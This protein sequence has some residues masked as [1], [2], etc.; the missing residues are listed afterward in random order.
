MQHTGD[1]LLGG[2]PFVSRT[3][4]GTFKDT[5]F[6]LDMDANLYIGPA[7]ALSRDEHSAI[8]VVFQF[9]R[10]T[11]KLECS[12]REALSNRRRL[13]RVFNAFDQ[14]RSDGDAEEFRIFV[15]GSYD[16]D[17]LRGISDDELPAGPCGRSINDLKRRFYEI[18]RKVDSKFTSHELNEREQKVERRFLRSD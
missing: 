13:L 15:F 8:E 3:F 6:V 17:P 18:C 10:Q 1:K 16:G 11:G 12:V 5:P 14:A 2:L 4:E 9:L 7:D